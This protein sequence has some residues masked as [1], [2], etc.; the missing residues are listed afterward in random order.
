[1]KLELALQALSMAIAIPRPPPSVRAAHLQHTD[2]ASQY[3]SPNYQKV[4]LRHR[5][6]VSTTGKGNRYENSAV[7]SFLSVCRPN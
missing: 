6:K 1:M 4:L 2:R 5:F 7:E 3:C